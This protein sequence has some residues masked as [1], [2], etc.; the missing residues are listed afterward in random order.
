MSYYKLVKDLVEK[1]SKNSSSSTRFILLIFSTR[2]FNSNVFYCIKCILH[3]R[4]HIKSLF[5]PFERVF[6][7][8]KSTH[9]TSLQTGVHRLS[10]ADLHTYIVELDSPVL[11]GLKYIFGNIVHV[12]WH[13]LKLSVISIG[14]ENKL[15][16][17]SDAPDRWKFSF[18]EDFCHENGHC[19]DQDNVT[20]TMCAPPSIASLISKSVSWKAL[21]I[22]ENSRL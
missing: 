19:G 14:L 7:I 21:N 15:I 11:R 1:I 8:C 16:G 12:T 22:T 2:Y 5:N 4:I 13:F 9:S 20:E 17:Q 10:S 3:S 18:G 6:R